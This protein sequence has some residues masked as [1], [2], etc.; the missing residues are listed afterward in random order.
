M[1]GVALRRHALHP[2]TTRLQTGLWRQRVPKISVTVWRSP[3]PIV[4]EELRARLAL[5]STKVRDVAAGA[6]PSRHA[7]RATGTGPSFSR[8][9]VCHGIISPVPS[10]SITTTAT[11]ARTNQIVG[12]VLQDMLNA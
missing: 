5:P 8:I 3:A 4:L 9:R 6:T 10:V 7:S 1:G 2:P 12:G 11:T